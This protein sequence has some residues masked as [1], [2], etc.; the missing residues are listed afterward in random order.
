MLGGKAK[1]GTTPTALGAMLSASVYGS[2]VPLIIGTT[3]TPLLM[4]WLQN[5]RSDFRLFRLRVHDPP[6]PLPDVAYCYY[7]R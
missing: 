5:L 4:T 2:T 3:R 7:P 1:S 6:Y